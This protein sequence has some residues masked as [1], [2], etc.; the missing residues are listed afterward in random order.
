MYLAVQD[1]QLT[2]CK[3]SDDKLAMLAILIG[4]NY[5]LDS[6]AIRTTSTLIGVEG[7]R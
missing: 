4:L 6:L 2:S 3:L 7:G 1:E 5:N